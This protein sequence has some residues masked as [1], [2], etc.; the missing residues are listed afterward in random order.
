LR[1]SQNN[2]TKL[3]LYKN[4]DTHFQ[5]KGVTNFTEG[6]GVHRIETIYVDRADCSLEAE[7]ILH[8]YL[9]YEH[10]TTSTPDGRTCRSN[11]RVTD[12]CY[13]S[14]RRI[15]CIARTEPCRCSSSIVRAPVARARAHAMH[16]CQRMHCPPFVRSNDARMRATRSTRTQSNRNQCA[17]CCSAVGSAMARPLP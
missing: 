10:N 13:G 1:V 14:T 9:R 3:V 16:E 6:E 12:K 15:A 4:A 7:G 2:S 8:L 11:A 5:R 17:C